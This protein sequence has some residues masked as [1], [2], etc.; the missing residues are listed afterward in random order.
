MHTL[1]S[2]GKIF[3]FASAK[4]AWLI[5]PSQCSDIYAQDGEEDVIPAETL[6]SSEKICMPIPFNSELLIEIR[7]TMEIVVLSIAIISLVVDIAICK[8][9]KLVNLCLYLE[10]LYLTSTLTFGA[11]PLQNEA[12]NIVG[13]AINLLMFVAFYCHS[14]GQIFFTCFNQGVFSFIVLP[15]IFLD[16][17]TAV[18]VLIKLMSILILFTI[19]TL[20]A[21]I[22][23]Y[24][25]KLHNRMQM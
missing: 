3:I 16:K 5:V 7:P 18:S 13:A 9:R 23:S 14:T 25:S 11:F 8:W 12:A 4:S 1:L 2:V 20:F 6:V 21:M 19:L 24:I 15:I 22:L 17:L 10:M